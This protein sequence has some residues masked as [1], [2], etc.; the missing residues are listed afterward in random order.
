VF[1][2]ISGREF[3]F[4]GRVVK[5]N[6]IAHRVGEISGCLLQRNAMYD[7][8]HRLQASQSMKIEIRYSSTS[9]YAVVNSIEVRTFMGQCVPLCQR[10]CP[11][12]HFAA[13]ASRDLKPFLRKR[14]H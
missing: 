2:K 6:P 12:F 10:T 14:R 5:A 8:V 9:F 7:A 1:W 11:C 4:A 13:G 3:D